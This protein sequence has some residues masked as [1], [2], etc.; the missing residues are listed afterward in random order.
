MASG[1][2]VSLLAASI[3]AF[4]PG[5]WHDRM[6]TI[7]NYE[8][9][10]SAMGR[11]FAWKTAVNIANDRVTGAGY[12]MY[13]KSIFAAYAPDAGGSRF[14]SKIA[15]AAHSIYFQVLGEHGYVGLF[16]FLMV[17]VITWRICKSLRKGTRGDPDV[18]WLYHFG[19]MVQVA[20]VAWVVGGAF[21]SLA[22]WDFPYSLTAA[23][24]VAQ[25]WRREHESLPEVN[26]PM[27]PSDL[28][29][30]GMRARFIW[31]IRT[32]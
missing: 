23:V 16:L 28:A 21:L 29:R 10:G 2:I 14:D 1:L 25:R 18:V 4:M 17:W 24:I 12:Q 9:D 26:P 3:W 22:Y 5:S 8:Q 6:D 19:S 7:Q 27:P 13:D 31:W 15:R 32:A 30:R 20:L 11:I